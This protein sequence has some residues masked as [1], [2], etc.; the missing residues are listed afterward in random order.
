MKRLT[1]TILLLRASMAG[2]NCPH[3]D[4]GYDPCRYQ[5]V[6][7][8]DEGQGCEGDESHQLRPQRDYQGH[9]ACVSQYHELEL[10]QTRQSP[11]VGFL[12]EDP[13]PDPLRN[14]S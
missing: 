7:E 9:D 3:L 14:E 5:L 4:R 12:L 10:Q 1:S 11:A 13:V 6:E 8:D 2:G